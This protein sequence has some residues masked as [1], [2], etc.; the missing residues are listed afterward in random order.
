[1][2]IRLLLFFY[3]TSAYLGAT[4]IH[5]DALKSL[6]DCKVHFLVKN[7][8]SGDT[9][10]GLFE[11]L[12]CLGCF[13]AIFFYTTHTVQALSKGFDAQAPPFLF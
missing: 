12:G 6:N 9:P 4:H 7:L 13:E 11:L 5:Q 3:L 8:N 10:H 1:M 2:I